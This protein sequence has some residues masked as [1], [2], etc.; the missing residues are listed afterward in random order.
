M[1]SILS[2]RFLDAVPIGEGSEMAHHVHDSKLVGG[3]VAVCSFDKDPRFIRVVTKTSK[4]E[5]FL[6]LVPLSNVSSIVPNS[7]KDD[8]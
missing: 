3:R 4:G 5:D 2:V 8:K 6:N 7:K 1:S